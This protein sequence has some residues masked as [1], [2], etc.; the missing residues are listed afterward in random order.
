[1]SAHGLRSLSARS[2]LYQKHNTE[3][4]PP[5]WRGA[6]WLNINYL[7]LEA[8]KSYAV[9]I[10]PSDLGR[11]VAAT[12][13]ALRNSIVR[14]VLEQGK[15][16]CALRLLLLRPPLKSLFLLRLRPLISYFFLCFCF[17][18]LTLNFTAATCSSNTTTPLARARARTRSRDGRRSWC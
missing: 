8:L 11:D 15:T 17:S 5:Y 16:R 10:G 14:T 9:R 18:L 3:H 1:M 6:V 12:N 2:S 4:D 13:L 7:V